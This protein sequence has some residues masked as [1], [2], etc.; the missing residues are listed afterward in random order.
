[1]SKGSTSG[2]NKSRPPAHQNETAFRHNKSSKKTKKILES[3]ISDLLC[4]SCKAVIEWRKQYRRYKP[5][6][7]S[8]KCVS[9]QKKSIKSAYH[10][11]CDDCST[12]ANVCAKCGDPRSYDKAKASAKVNYNPKVS[13]D[14]NDEN[15]GEETLETESPGPSIEEESEDESDFSD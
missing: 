8:K 9:C 3:P 15:E 6:T 11:R 5:L 4:P 13:E 2:S 14:I 7:V 1:M 12:N 10:T